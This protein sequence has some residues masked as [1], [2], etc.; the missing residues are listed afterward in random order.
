MLDTRGAK[1][2]SELDH[3]D[4]YRMLREEILEQVRDTRRLETSTLG[5]LAL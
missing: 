5:A 1:V 2:A 4:Q 3:A